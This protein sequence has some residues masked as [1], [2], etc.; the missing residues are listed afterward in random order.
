MKSYQVIELGQPL[1]PVE[2]DTPEPTGSQVLLK[3]IACGVC[4]SD[5]HLWHGGQDK[6][7]PLSVG[8]Y[9]AGELPDCLDRFYPEEGHLTLPRNRI[10][11]I[12]AALTS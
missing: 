4:H 10:A 1:E 7:V 9:V 6:N 11:E 12:L 2:T 5:V 3:T 8:Q